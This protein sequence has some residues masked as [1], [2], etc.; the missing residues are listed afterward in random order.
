M[1]F[2]DTKTDEWDIIIKP[3]DSKFTLNFRE[4]WKYKD[5]M[6]MYIRRDFVT[7]Y[8]QT[9]LGP[10]W[11]VLQPLFTTLMF[12][13]VFGGI[14]QIPTD[15]IPQPL[16]YFAGILC[17][18]YFGD[19]LGRSSST[20]SANASVFSKVYFP[21]LTVPVSGLVTN[22]I[23]LAIQLSMFLII[24]LYF[25]YVGSTAHFTAYIA[26]FPLLL[27]VVA[28]LGFGIGIIISSLTAKYRDL[29]ILFAF[30]SQLWM[31]AT[32]VIYPLSAV[33]DKVQKYAWILH[34][35]PMTSVVETTRLGFL[36]QGTFSWY[37]LAYS[38]VFAVVI[39]VIGIWVFNRVERNFIDTI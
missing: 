22:L 18:N 38:C 27:V 20:F 34:L 7:M 11:F 19:C 23:R 37:S 30:L 8:K 33:P 21:R 32:P 17:W 3:R 4:I 16:F 31:Y 13:F 15:G 29:A 9:V 25:Y 35:N 24:Y 1:G 12:M 5:L 26:L 2:K 14:A 10:L 39:T 36:G 28:G 6:R